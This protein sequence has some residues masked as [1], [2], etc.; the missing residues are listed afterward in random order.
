M[1]RQFPRPHLQL[2]SINPTRPDLIPTFLHVLADSRS[3]V[4]RLFTDVVIEF[5]THTTLLLATPYPR[6]RQIPMRHG[7]S[8]RSVDISDPPFRLGWKNQN[9]VE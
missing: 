3:E 6:L 4:L 2:L 8:I 7:T 5:S 9:F 1:S